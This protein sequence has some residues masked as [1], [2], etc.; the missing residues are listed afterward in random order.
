MKSEAEV[1]RDLR[2]EAPYFNV[3]LWR[4]NVGSM[5][6]IDRRDLCDICDEV[7]A[8]AVPVRFGLANESDKQNKDLK[9]GDL[10][11]WRS[12]L[13]TDDMVGKVVA[14]FI[15]REAKREGWAYTGTAREQAQ[16]NW[17]NLV[18]Q[19]GGHA[20]FVTGPGSFIP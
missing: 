7:Y 6:R 4:N 12:L 19:A 1:Q 14:Q 11:G 9:S 17:I 3:H 5:R 2:L 10:I 20:C 15:S 8:R 18:N 13:I 16:M